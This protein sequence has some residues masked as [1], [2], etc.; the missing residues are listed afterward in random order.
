LDPRVKQGAQDNRAFMRRAT[1]WLTE[2]AGVRQFLDIGTGIPTEPNLH[3]VAQAID[4]TVRVVYG[5]NDPIVL[6]HAG[7]LLRSTP[8]G[9]TEYID[10]DIREPESIVS[11]A[12]RILDFDQPIALTLMS[13]MH[14]IPDE[15]GAHDHVHALMDAL[16][17]G[18]HLVLSQLTEDVHPDTMQ[19]A[20]RVYGA[21]GISLVYRSHAEVERFFTGLELLDPG[22]V[23]IMKWHPELAIAELRHDNEVPVYAGVGR[24]P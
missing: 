9:V 19:T 22:V 7:A 3:Q 8:Q 21:H 17:S 12:R 23:Q 24:K 5:D 2:T 20:S 14:F 13:L 4:P 6:A 15:D 18:S 10:V 16:P 1:R 11:K